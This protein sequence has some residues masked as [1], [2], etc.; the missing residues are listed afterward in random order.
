[1]L[2]EPCCRYLLLHCPLSFVLHHLRSGEFREPL[3]ESGSPLGYLDLSL[4]AGS[5][6]QGGWVREEDFLMEKLPKMLPAPEVRGFREECQRCHFSY[7]P[8]RRSSWSG[9]RATRKGLKYVV[10]SVRTFAFAAPSKTAVEGPVPAKPIPREGGWPSGPVMVWM[11]R[12]S[13]EELT[14]TL[15]S[16]C[17]FWESRLQ[18]PNPQGYRKRL[19]ELARCSAEGDAPCG[20]SPTDLV[21]LATSPSAVCASPPKL[22]DFL[23]KA[24]S[25]EQCER[26]RETYVHTLEWVLYMLGRS[27]LEKRL[28]QG[29]FW[30]RKKLVEAAVREAASLP[31]VQAEDGSFSVAEGRLPSSL[32]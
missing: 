1:M 32:T 21:P 6:R 29:E 9:K 28:H 2:G 5:K 23:R 14:S 13:R 18:V 31:I 30:R 26:I 20:F 25:R 24:V 3:L 16:I 7:D 11:T 27:L 22:G 15:S 10:R 12:K 17:H 19:F 8:R 4:A